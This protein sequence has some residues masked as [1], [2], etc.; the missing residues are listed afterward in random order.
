MARTNGIID[1]NRIIRINPKF[2]QSSTTRITDTINKTDTDDITDT[3]DV[4]DKG[5]ALH[6]QHWSRWFDNL[7]RLRRGNRLLRAEFWSTG[8]ATSVAKVAVM[9]ALLDRRLRTFASAQA[10]T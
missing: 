9:S 5:H 4:S 8:V 2:K 7:L 6:S 3:T 1:I 10:T